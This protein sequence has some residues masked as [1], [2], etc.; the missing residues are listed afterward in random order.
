MFLP[1]FVFLFR[2]REWRWTVWKS[3]WRVCLR[4]ARPTWLCPGLGVWRACA[5]WTL[6]PGWSGQI[7]RF[8]SSIRNCG[9]RSC[10]CRW[11][12]SSEW[13]LEVSARVL[14]IVPSVSVSLQ[15][16]MDDFVNNKENYHW[17]YQSHLILCIV[18][19]S[20]LRVIVLFNFFWKKVVLRDSRH[21]HNG[22][23]TLPPSGHCYVFK[24]LFLC[25]KLLFIHYSNK[26]SVNN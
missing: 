22:A 5:W 9:R 1:I 24:S 14:T 16:S 21:V 18:C 15:A 3:R 2:S 25:F 26:L 13:L 19:M 6:T 11:G 4:A 12:Q 7:Q 23:V 8:S 20:F 17:I 10:S